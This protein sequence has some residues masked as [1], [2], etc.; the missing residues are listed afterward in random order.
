MR[1]IDGKFAIDGDEIV[2][3]SNGDK[4][5]HDEPVI[6]LRA[7]DHISLYALRA[8]RAMCIVDKC[9]DYQMNGIDEVI[10]KFEE[11]KKKNPERMKQPGITRGQ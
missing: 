10:A 4:I 11:F 7:R 5:P 9:N 8:Y 3:I 2:K 6:V 1:A